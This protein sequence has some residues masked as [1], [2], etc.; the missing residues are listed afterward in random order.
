MIETTFFL[1]AHSM[2]NILLRDTV[3]LLCVSVPFHVKERLI[4]QVKQPL[5]IT[6]ELYS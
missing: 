4:F 1:S 5:D 6:V 2:K 3:I